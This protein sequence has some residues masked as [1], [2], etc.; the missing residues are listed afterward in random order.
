M[1]KV[2]FIT[3]DDLKKRTPLGGNIDPDKFLNM[4]R[5]AQDIH[6]QPVIGTRLYKKLEADVIGSTLTGDYLTLVNDYIKDFLV[7]KAASDYVVFG[8]FEI[9]NG[10]V[11]RHEAENATSASRGDVD[12]LAQKLADKSG[13]YQRRMVDYL[14]ANIS[15][16]PEYT[17][18]QNGDM[19]KNS[20]DGFNGLYF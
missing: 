12:Y 13:H 19:P 18:W 1:A 6:L 9:G 5:A 7:W 16:F 3:K 14:C 20:K 2:L 10:G 17:A 8:A 4:I 15:A 11:F